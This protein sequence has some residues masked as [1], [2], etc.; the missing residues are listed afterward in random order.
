[1]AGGDL[2]FIFAFII[3][4]TAVLVSCIWALILL[5]KGV[6][7]PERPAPPGQYD[8]AANRDDDDIDLVEETGE[9]V[10]IDPAPVRATPAPPPA[11]AVAPQERPS[12]PRPAPTA[13]NVVSNTPRPTVERTQELEAVPID[14]RP[15]LAPKPSSGAVHASVEP[16]PQ[17]S[18][19]VDEG[20]DILL[21]PLEEPVRV[22]TPNGRLVEDVSAVTPPPEPSDGGEDAEAV[23]AAPTTGAR[24][25]TRRI[26]QPR[27]AATDPARPRP[28]TGQRRSNRS[29]ESE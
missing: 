18:S 25:P 23:P 6:L 12:E 20:G 4:P 7:L 11:S 19:A 22:T 14:E 24:R 9:H 27:P 1:M 15:A 26:A 2:L 10:V 13:S 5:R 17:A 28:R 8:L 21:I 16:D 3:L 29:G